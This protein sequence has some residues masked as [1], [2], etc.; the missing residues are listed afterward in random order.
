MAQDPETEPDLLGRMIAI[1]RLVKYVLWSLIVRCVDETGG[2][3]REAIEEVR[4]LRE[5]VTETLKVSSFR[6]IY[7]ALPDEMVALVE[8]HVERIL[9][10][11][12]EEMEERLGR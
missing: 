4:R 10:E 3:D 7:P 6:G 11:L 2:S 9:R 8:D 12:T 1:E 5:D